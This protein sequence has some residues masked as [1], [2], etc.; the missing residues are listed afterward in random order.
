MFD[1]VTFCR[2]YKRYM[3]MGNIVLACTVT[4]VHTMFA[5]ICVVSPALA[6]GVDGSYI[7]YDKDSHVTIIYMT[8]GNIVLACTVTSVHT[9]FPTICVVSLAL[10]C[11]V[12]G[13]YIDYYKDSHVTII[14]HGCV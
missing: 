14:Y 5:T 7:D 12:D 8:M 10:A 11:G 4:S 9:M 2:K 3:T 6:C 1:R 13:S